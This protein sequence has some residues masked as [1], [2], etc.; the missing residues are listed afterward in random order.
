MT[1][2]KIIG[3]VVTAG[4]VAGVSIP[5]IYDKQIN[6]FIQTQ[7]E[8]LKI[9]KIEFKENSNKDSFLS[10]NREYTL[11]IKDITPIVQK[12][13]P[14]IDIYTLKDLKKSFDNTKFTIKLN[15]LKYPVYHKDA[16]KIYLKSFNEYTTKNLNTN[17]YGKQI[18]EFIKNKGLEVILDLNNMDIAKA[19]LKDINLK[20]NDK[21]S[22]MNINIK[23]SY[24]TFENNIETNIDNLTIKM[25]DK[26][27]HIKFG[28]NKLHSKSKQKNQ[29]NYTEE[30]TLKDIFYTFNKKNISLNNLKS[31]TK[32]STIVNNLKVENKLNIQNIKLS[33][34]FI[35]SSIQNLV[36]N[37]QIDKINFV[38]IKKLVNQV[39]NNPNDT[40]QLL[41]NL[42]E[43]INKGF[44]F[45]ISPFSIDSANIDLKTQKFNISKIK[46]DFNT[47]LKTNQFNFK[48]QNELLKNLDANLMIKTT[49]ENIDLLTKI[50][51]AI[52][53]YLALI[54]KQEKDNILINIS[55]KNGKIIS[56]GKQLF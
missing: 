24:M 40:K 55:Y 30:S 1:F 2:S 38:A 8:N 37:T 16:V 54:S 25:D 56:N 50:N 21:N 19:K 26:Y 4:I 20:L 28:F 39:Q 45:K 49:K 23:N 48:N 46:V 22:N 53:I 44:S 27:D 43:V 14:N 10:T 9:Q 7:S 11:I 47:E 34:N 6:K 29:F 15:I 18:F 12:L 3:G 52:N 51:P 17:Q 36:F 35:S 5:I 41:S 33:D 31:S 13:Y 42:Q 32:V